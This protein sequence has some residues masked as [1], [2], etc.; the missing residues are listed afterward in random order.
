MHINEVW[1]FLN[2]CIYVC[3]F[4]CMKWVPASCSLDLSAFSSF[5]YVVRREIFFSRIFSRSSSRLPCICMYGS[6]VCVTTRVSINTLTSR[7]SICWIWERGIL[8][9]VRLFSH[10]WSISLYIQY[11]HTYIQCISNRKQRF[12]EDLTFWTAG[13]KCGCRSLWTPCRPIES[14]DPA[15]PMCLH[16]HTI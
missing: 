12:L 2:A 14:A 8:C 5:L 11:I 15:L 1:M 7:A 10:F 13:R 3:M 4:V 16:I 9:P 6:D